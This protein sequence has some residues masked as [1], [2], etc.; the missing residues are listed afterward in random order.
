M[1]AELSTIYALASA[2]G[3]A[4]VSVIRLSGPESHR[5][6]GRL[7]PLPALRTAALR[8]LVWAGEV[9]DTAI[10][11]L[12]AKGASFTGED[13]AELHV[14]GS[15][16]VVARLLRVL[17]ETGLARPALAGEFT[18]RALQNGQLDLAQVE[19]LADLLAA[20]T[21]LQRRQAVRS[22]SGDLGRQAELWRRQLIR[23]AALVE[24]CIDFGEEG[25]TSA[26]LDEAKSSLK[27][28]SSLWDT[29]LAGFTAAER[30]REG[31]EVAIVGAPN[32]GKST[33]LN[34][35][36][37]RDAAITSEIAGTTRD[38]IEV[39]MDIRG[40][41]VTLLD[42][43][44]LR[45]TEDTVEKIGI[46]RGVNRAQQADLR[47][48]LLDTVGQALPLEPL[49]G[50][51]C[52]RAKA[53]LVDGEGGIS[54]RTGQGVAQ[55]LDRIAE[56]LA[57][58]A[59]GSGLVVRERQRV[60]LLAA[61]AAIQPLLSADWESELAPE[62]IAVEIRAAIRHLEEMVG[63]IGTEDFLGEIFATFCIGK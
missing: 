23:A 58:L 50:D 1:M 40:I 22:L 17:G 54:G 52:L 35:I 55:L 9:I 46:Q 63:R 27:A 19:G 41:P 47:V 42:T 61:Q 37:R 8:R 4:G 44:G 36:A 31:F 25:V 49:V 11:L 56:C 57:P 12:F 6:V 24:A 21:E 16:A 26:A 20:E 5:V 62:L 33:L 59:T 3:K 45:E 18:R 29:E 60:A 48:F 34:A 43:A 15:V 28:V 2:K 51:I 32:V 53:D 38:V 7:C 39:R 10:V 14:H 30:V 13:S